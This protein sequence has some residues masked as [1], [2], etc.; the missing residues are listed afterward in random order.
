MQSS[1]R[2]RASEFVFF[3]LFASAVTLVTACSGQAVTPAPATSVDRSYESQPSSPFAML[4]A[5]PKPSSSPLFAAAYRQSKG[6]IFALDPSFRPFK[7]MREIRFL[8]Q[9]KGLAVNS[10]GTLYATDYSTDKVYAFPRGKSQPSES[11]PQPSGLY[12]V[13]V[14]IGGDGTMYVADQGQG[15]SSTTPV[16][17]EVYPKG[18]KKPKRQIKETGGSVAVA[19]VA[20]DGANNL[21]LSYLTSASGSVLAVTKF[22]PGSSHGQTIVLDPTNQSYTGGF[23]VDH[24][25]NL[26]VSPVSVKPSGLVGIG[27]YPPGKSTPS[28]ILSV[29]SALPSYGLV[30]S[31]DQKIIYTCSGD[32]IPVTSYSRGTL[33]YTDH[34]G[35]FA[36]FGLGGS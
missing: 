1:R 32:A 8:Q 31:G 25:G 5:S 6:T 33:L 19:R 35:G 30:V 23:G 14:A 4:D 27:V 34:I 29:G 7:V 2:I 28:R 22:A 24:Q 10:A 11:Y 18:S 16:Y 17:V 3:V 36:V 21:Y 20:L 26:L 13:S 15:T 9:P 12:P